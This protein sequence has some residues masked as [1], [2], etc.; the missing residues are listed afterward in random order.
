V[1]RETN[2]T[3]IINMQCSTDEVDQKEVESLLHDID[4]HIL[5]STSK[6]IRKENN[7][8][9]FEISE[10]LIFEDSPVDDGWVS[11][12]SSPLPGPKFTAL[13][14]PE[15]CKDSLD[16]ENLEVRPCPIPFIPH[17]ELAQPSS[18][19]MQLPIVPAKTKENCKIHFE[20]EKKSRLEGNNN[21]KSQNCM[22]LR[23]STQPCNSNKTDYNVALR[24]LAAKMSQS[25]SSRMQL[26]KF[27]PHKRTQ[28]RRSL[29]MTL[30]VSSLS[31]QQIK[32]LI[33]CNLNNP[34]NVLLKTA[35]RSNA[36]L[37]RRNSLEMNNKTSMN[38]V[39]GEL[40]QNGGSMYS[41]MQ[42][43]SPAS[44]YPDDYLLPKQQTNGREMSFIRRHSTL[45]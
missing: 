8:N 25:E 26:E 19:Q 23:M 17:I 6:D 33:E 1:C 15:F 22:D 42:T 27:V 36:T 4:K 21:S 29:D 30:N 12:L 3:I 39:S 2:L 44:K 10:E 43:S 31:R 9:S 32:A 40:T 16:P 38:A 28:R 45:V 5:R 24:S 35:K 41:Y 14:T 13:K 18:S 11:P 20:A 7:N 37:Q 34:Q